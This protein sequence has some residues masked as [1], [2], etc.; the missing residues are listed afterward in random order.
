MLG[1]DWKAL[2]AFRDAMAKR[3]YS[4]ESTGRQAM[5]FGLDRYSGAGI[6]VS[7]ESDR[8]FWGIEIQPDGAEERDTLHVWS[9]CLG[10]PFISRDS[11]LKDQ[12]DYLRRRLSDIEAAC[13]RYRR[14]STT[15]C[16]GNARRA[17][18]LAGFVIAKTT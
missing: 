6:V 8:G 14:A 2:A 11:A 7:I 17:V 5:D 4:A 15:D 1:A 13:G 10:E 18:Q 16:L 12:L 9:I 3:G